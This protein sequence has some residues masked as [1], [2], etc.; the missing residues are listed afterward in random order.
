MS[1]TPQTRAEA[2]ASRNVNPKVTYAAG[3]A[4]VGS[5][6]STIAVW[7]INATAGVT[8][9]QEVELALGVVLT[10]GLAFVGGWYKRA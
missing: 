1:S 7:I 4:A 2:R 5:A 9:P 10:A 8:V 6:V 3:G